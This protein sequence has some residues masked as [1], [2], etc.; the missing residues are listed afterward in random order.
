MARLPLRPLPLQAS[1]AFARRHH[2]Y[3]WPTIASTKRRSSHIRPSP[4]GMCMATTYVWPLLARLPLPM[5][6]YRLCGHHFCTRAPLLVRA[7]IVAVHDHC[8]CA[9]A[10]CMVQLPPTS[11]HRHSI[12][13]YCCVAMLLPT[14]SLLLTHGHNVRHYKQQ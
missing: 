14:H 6:G 1:I 5:G 12:D 7:T 2:L 9:Q 11:G 13:A 3:P 8:L 10:L 4:L